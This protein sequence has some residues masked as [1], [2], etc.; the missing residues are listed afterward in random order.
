MVESVKDPVARRF[1][2]VSLRDI[3]RV[4]DPAHIILFGSRAT[5]RAGES[6]DI[7]LIIVSDRFRDV[8]FPNRMGAFLRAIRPE[9]DVEA[10]CY[11]PDEFEALK[12]QLSPVAEAA[13]EGIWIQ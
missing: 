5:G 3:R 13:R 2:E 7:D 8:P 12:G 10:F 4:F 9:P 1:L 11:T 6:S